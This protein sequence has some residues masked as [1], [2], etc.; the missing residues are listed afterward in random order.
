MRS[1]K[2]SSDHKD[3][4]NQRVNTK[5]LTQQRLSEELLFSR[6]TVSKFLNCRPVSIINF[7][8]I[9]RNLGFEDWKRIACLPNGDNFLGSDCSTSLTPRKHSVLEKCI[10]ALSE[11][12]ALLKIKAP[13][14]RGKTTTAL[15]IL[16]D[17]R[18]QQNYRTVYLSLDSVDNSDYQS[19]NG[20]L[21][22]FCLVIGNELNISNQQSDYWDNPVS[23]VRCTSYVENTFLLVD[24]RP[25]VLCID[26]LDRIFPHVEI[27]K[28]FFGLLRSWHEKAKSRE[29]WQQLRLVLLYCTE[30]YGEIDPRESP[31][32][33]GT[34]ATPPKFTAE[35]TSILA[36]RYGLHWSPA[37]TQ[38]LME[39]VGG[40]PYL[41]DE[42]LTHWKD[43]SR[44][45]DEQLKLEADPT[46]DEI[47]S[48]YLQL[49]WR[50]VTEDADL[51]TELQKILDSPMPVAINSIDLTERLIDIGIIIRTDVNLVQPYCQLFRDYFQARINRLD[52]ENNSG[53]KT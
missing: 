1:I 22:W 23:K 39:V 47:Y 15:D 26:R 2:L 49:L 6:S 41:I 11:P 36:E 7:E 53:D 5:Y 30:N 38:Q 40:H 34:L 43:C 20:F 32:N 27:A 42:M 19:F 28:D 12:G 45:L 52:Q 24:D 51:V 29:I 4:V 3:S 25:L 46:S 33:I 14:K 17:L 21:K 13:R 44:P 31:F 18:E 35:Q 50:A 10:K 16:T 48:I 9:A 8:E 37:S